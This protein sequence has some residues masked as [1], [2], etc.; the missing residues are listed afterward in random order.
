MESPC[1]RQDLIPGTSK[2]F[3]DYLYCFERVSN[4]YSGHFSDTNALIH[5]ARRLR[6]PELRRAQ[7]IDALGTQNSESPSLSALAQPD[8]VAV[9]TGQQVGLFSGPAYTIFKA[10]TA[11]KLA[12]HLSENG[13]AAVPIFWLATEDHDLAEVDHAWVF[14]Q[15]ATPAK[16]SL[17]NTLST[18]GPVGD[19]L[20]G[21]LPIEDLRAALG[22]LPFAD[23]VLER[24]QAAYQPGATFGSAFRSFLKDL[25]T[26]Y[27]ILYLD[28]LASPIRD[29]AAP[30]MREVVER[31][32]ELVSA[33]R[34]RDRELGSAGYHSQVLVDDDASLLFLLEN[35]KRLPIRFKDGRFVTR[36]RSY[37]KTELQSLASR[38][39]PNA[40]LRPVMQDFLL[41]T[42]SYIGGPAEVAYLAQSQV[43]YQ[44]LLGRMPVIYPRN[45]FTLLDQRA[46][47]LLDR[48]GLHTIDLLDHQENVKGRLAAKLVPRN[49]T[50]ELE[51]LRSATAS[52]LTALDTKLLEFDPSLAAA[53][54]KSAAKVL[55]QMDKLSRKVARETLR[56]DERASQNATYLID[57]VYPHRRMQERIYSIVPFLAK[58]GLDLPARLFSEV[59]LACPDHMVRIL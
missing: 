57:L 4:F 49:L 51:S 30:F 34:Q 38:L 3:N 48:F 9:V 55:Y 26:D 6:F 52:S 59:Q 39:S 23:A 33:L 41:P 18:G 7:L 8:A 56:R 58:Y 20:L 44:H 17:A 50:G 1:V 13:A 35:G 37:S 15:Q 31:V 27:G 36:D 5:S 2:L 22:D 28:P 54:K 11:V 46:M 40:L 42:A 14:D 10:L 12:K 21:D 19:V 25:L 43:L 16:V 45:S 29:I 32:P 47:K 24:V 53:S